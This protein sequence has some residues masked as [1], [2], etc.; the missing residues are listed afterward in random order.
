MLSVAL[1]GN[2]AAGKSTVGLLLE[3]SGATL[4]DADR[5]VHQ[6]EQ[7]GTAVFDAIV[8]R[9]GPDVLAADG[10]LDRARLRSRVFAQPSEREALNAI[11]HP[12]V[13]RERERLVREAR[14]RGDRIVV[15]DIPLLFEVMDPGAFDVVI[16][17]DAPI[18][19]RRERLMR[20]RGLDRPAADAMME[21]Q[22]PAELKRA[23]S[24]FVI[25]NDADLAT[26]RDRVAAVWRELERR[27][28]AVERT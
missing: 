3:G 2:I 15:N 1:T 19:V 10:T 18:A 14:R 4:I 27:A 28:R 22:L 9:F 20:A 13:A 8:R 7:P 12:A 5:I 23:R 11:V 17:V 6:L 21:A 24:T 26:L 25:E 16:L